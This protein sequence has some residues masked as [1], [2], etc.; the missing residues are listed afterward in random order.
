MDFKLTEEQ[1]ALQDTARRFAQNELLDIAR[2]VENDD[3]PP[4][5]DV[6]QLYAKMGFLGINLDEEYGGAGLGHFEAV[7]VLEQIAKISA[8]VAFP[9]FESCF[10]PVLAI[11][12]F[13]SEPLKRRIIPKVCSGEMIVAVSMSEPGAGSALTDLTTQA[14]IDGDQIVLNGQKRWCSGA[15]HSQAY[16]VY[17]RM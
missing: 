9:I 12:K 3:E 11:Q 2:Q 7:L 8:S 17:C 15:G 16:V 1:Q 10:G 13:A 6:M 5:R 4:G 14:R